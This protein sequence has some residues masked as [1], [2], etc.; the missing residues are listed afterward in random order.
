MRLVLRKVRRDG[1]LTSKSKTF[2]WAWRMVPYVAA[3]AAPSLAATV[4]ARL[5]SLQRDIASLND[6]DAS[7]VRFI[8]CSMPP[9]G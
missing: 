1:D 2:C 9:S 7:P 6:Y 5:E 8:F 3:N 4:R